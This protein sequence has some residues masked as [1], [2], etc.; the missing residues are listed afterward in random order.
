LEDPGAEFRQDYLEGAENA[1]ARLLPEESDWSEVVRVIDIPATSAGSHLELVMDG[2][3]GAA[4][5]YIN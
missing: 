2:D 3:A 5:A 1:L 4:M